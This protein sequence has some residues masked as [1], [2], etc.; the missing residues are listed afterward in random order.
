MASHAKYNPPKARTRHA[1]LACALASCSG[2]PSDAPDTRPNLLLVVVDDLGF[3]DLSCTGSTTVA[4]PNIDRL[5]EE[6]VSCTQA[7]VTSSLCSPSRAGL[8]VGRYQQRFGH[9]HN[10]G[11]VTRQAEL[12]IGLPLGQRTLAEDLNDAG[13]DTA[14]I[15]KWHLGVDAAFH[16]LRRGFESFFGH[17]G[18][19]HSYTVWSDPATGPILRNET[20]AEGTAYLTDAFSDEAVRFLARER[21]RPFFL[22]LAY[23]APHAPLEAP[24]GTPREEA[25][26]DRATY[27]AMVTALDAGLGRVLE[28]LDTKGIAEETLVVLLNDNGAPRTHPTDNQP[29]RGFKQSHYEGGIRVP[30]LLRW[31]GHLPAGSLHDGLVSALDVAPTFQQ[32]AGLEARTDSDGVDLAPVL[33]GE[34]EGPAHDALFWRR[35]HRRAARVGDW[36]LVAVRRRVELFNLAVDPGE[37]L[38]VADENPERLEELERAYATWEAGLVPPL[39]EWVDREDR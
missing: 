25:G 17:L 4:T 7:Y 33:S 27:V 20:E 21:D 22:Y 28:A 11:D 35:G 14:A 29:F 26:D 39:W 23:N 18:G 9:E 10:T 1:L 19:G 3:G 16:P 13:Y 36:K 34:R 6:G 31:P 5:A 38:D 8:L 32:A 24:P 37:Q 30:F 12:G 2:A 15:G